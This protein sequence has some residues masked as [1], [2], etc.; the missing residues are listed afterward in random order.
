MPLLFPFA[1]Y[2]WFYA[3][4]TAFVLMLLAVDLGIF[5]RDAQVV[6]FRESLT[7][8]VI[9]VATA[10]LFTRGFYQYVVGKFGP[11]A[12]SGLNAADSLTSSGGWQWHHRPRPTMTCTT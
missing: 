11:P 7:W 3:G 8:S 5:H 12:A 10:L 2:W 9:W 4:F 6:S 1:E